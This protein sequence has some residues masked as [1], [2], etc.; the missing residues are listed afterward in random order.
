MTIAFFVH[1]LQKTVPQG[2]VNFVVDT[3]DQIRHRSIQHGRLYQF[4]CPKSDC[5]IQFWFNP[6]VL[7]RF[8]L[9]RFGFT[10]VFVI[11][12]NP[13]VIR[14]IRSIRSIRACALKRFGAQA[15]HPRSMP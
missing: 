15:C 6:F 10:P 3:D 14:S 2:V 11:R 5:F 7:F 13:V 1:F 12:F 8:G 9:F 4:N